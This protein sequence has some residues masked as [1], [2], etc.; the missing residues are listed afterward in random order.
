MVSDPTVG[1]L[2]CVESIIAV[3]KKQVNKDLT[4]PLS[5]PYRVST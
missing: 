4:N 3:L 2:K 1:F 5:K